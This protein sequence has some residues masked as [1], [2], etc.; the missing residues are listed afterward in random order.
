MGPPC[1]PS[2]PLAAVQTLYSALY[3]G[4][5]SEENLGRNITAC[6]IAC[7]ARVGD[8]SDEREQVGSLREVMPRESLHGAISPLEGDQGSG[9]HEPNKYS[10]SSLISHCAAS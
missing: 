3:L 9:D 6:C 2:R 8:G 10:M 1:D 4:N 5:A 7:A